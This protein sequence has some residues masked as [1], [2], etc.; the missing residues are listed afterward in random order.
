MEPEGEVENM[1]IETIQNLFNVTQTA[2]YWIVNGG[3]FV[4][5]LLLFFVARFLIARG[6]IYLAQRTESRY[7]DIVVEKLRPYRFAWI[8]P[9]VLVY[10]FTTVIHK[11]RNNASW[12]I[13]SVVVGN[14]VAKL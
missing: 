5:S 8:A 14:K 6:L 10:N 7:D 13:N 12:R 2:A 1:T 11:I 9:L 3:I 4:L